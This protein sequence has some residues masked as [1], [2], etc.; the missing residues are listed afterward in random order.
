MAFTDGTVTVEVP[1]TSANLG[2]GFDCLGLA[3]DLHDTLTAA[4]SDALV[5]EIDGE[6][7]G[8]LP[9]DEGHL[10]LRAM[11]AAFDLIGERP[12]GVHLRCH[13]RIP[14]SRGLGSSSA[15]IVGGI[16]LAR[17]LVEDGPARL[18]LRRALELATALEGHPDNVAPALFGGLVISG[19]DEQEVWADQ[20]PVHPDVSVVVLVPP[21]ALPTE[22]ARGLL[23]DV[24][25]HGDAAAAAGRAALL[26]AALA[27]AP[28][29]LLRGTEDFL[30]QSYREPAMP[31]TLA[32]VRR[33]RDAD[34]PAV[35]SGAGPTVLAFVG[36][37]LPPA[38][39]VDA[40]AGWQRLELSVAHAGAHRV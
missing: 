26:V 13:N 37:G 35:V 34:V 3:L 5:V 32:L 1:A 16:V 33:L 40:P 2:P 14:Q 38:S 20:A 9:R 15:A 12:D 36:P 7:S 22:V 39:A 29:R 23:P 19:Q 17:E 31:E 18:P 30:H 27:R 4:V 11:A 21:Q 28:E 24:V 10:V 6:G 8:D 25:P